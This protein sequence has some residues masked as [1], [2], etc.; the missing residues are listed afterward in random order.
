[1]CQAQWLQVCN[2]E[3]ETWL[4]LPVHLALSA[5]KTF[6]QSRHNFMTPTSLPHLNLLPVSWVL[7]EMC[8]AMCS[9]F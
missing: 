3:E 2:W 5:S 6:L 4:P 1:M 8:C 9:T 7:V